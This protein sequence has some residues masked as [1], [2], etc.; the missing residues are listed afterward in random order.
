MNK[1]SL[2]ANRKLNVLSRMWSFLSAE[3]RRRIFKSFIESQCKYC[4]LT[5]I[6]CSQKSNNKIS[7]LHER[8]W[9]IVNNGY[10]STYEERLSNNNCFTIHDQNI[11]HLAAEIYKVANDLSVG[12]FK[13]L[14]DFKDKYTI[15]IPLVNTELK[16]KNSVRYF[17][18]VVWNAIPINTKTATS[19]NDFKNRIKS[20]TRVF[21]S[22]L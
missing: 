11:H 13:N 15:Y 18:V 6:F 22:T 12:D 4:P 2:K 20:W 14:F 10:E 21:M 1:I 7:S 8:S 17:G 19:L 9:R 16:V 5:W 3:K